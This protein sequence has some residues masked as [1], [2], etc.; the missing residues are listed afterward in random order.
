MTTNQTIDGVPR[1]DLE[2]AL[3]ADASRG[4]TASELVAGWAAM[5]R[6][7]ALLD[8]RHPSEDELIANGLGYPFSKQEAVQ[9]YYSGFKT[10]PITVLEAW[11]AIGHDIGCNPSKEELLDSL[12]NMAAICDAHGNDMP[13]AQPHGEPVAWIAWS[14]GDCPVDAD[15]IVEYA[16]ACNPQQVCGP[17]AACRLDWRHDQRPTKRKPNIVKYRE[18]AEQPATVAVLLAERDEFVSW[19]RREW[20]QAPLSNVR[21]LLP[22]DDPRYGEYCD[23]ALQRAWVGWQARAAVVAKSR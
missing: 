15:S 23:E 20:P 14:G 17:E 7:R 10:E 19:V 8:A 12:R 22:K 1:A 3:K 2:A 6:L 5:E 4:A 11:D 18:I 21:D 16:M 9:L 13:A